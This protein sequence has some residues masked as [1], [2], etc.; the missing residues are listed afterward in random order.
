ML[1]LLVEIGFNPVRYQV[2]EDAP[3]ITFVVENRNPDRETEYQVQFTTIDGS[4][5]QATNGGF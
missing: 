1:F 4:A 2:N 5:I 3:M